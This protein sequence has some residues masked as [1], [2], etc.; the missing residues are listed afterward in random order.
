MHQTYT[1]QRT[2]FPV[3]WVTWE[4][5]TAPITRIMIMIG[6]GPYSCKGIFGQSLFEACFVSY[7]HF[8][9][10]NCNV[11]LLSVVKLSKICIGLWKPL[12]RRYAEK[13]SHGRVELDGDYT[14]WEPSLAL[15]KRQWNPNDPFS[16]SNDPRSSMDPMAQ[17]NIDEGE[18]KW[19]RENWFKMDLIDPAK[20]A[21]FEGDVV[22]VTNKLHRKSN[23]K[24]PFYPL[25]SWVFAL[26][27]NFENIYSTWLCLGARIEFQRAYL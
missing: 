7:R 12:N 1:L 17:M 2:L 25:F 8:G 14:A 5:W 19:F 15:H 23:R 9:V 24:C 21:L 16:S 13:K 20:W 6:K 22:L 18:L 10:K 27:P 26:W 4:W 3:T 11:I